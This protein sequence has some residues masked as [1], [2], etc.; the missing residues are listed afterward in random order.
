MEAGGWK[1]LKAVNT[2]ERIKNTRFMSS[3]FS[4]ARVIRSA[5]NSS[6]LSETSL[7]MFLK[8]YLKI[9]CVCYDKNNLFGQPYLD[10]QK[11]PSFSS[12]KIFFQY[13]AFDSTEMY[14]CNS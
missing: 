3:Y 6:L 10:C 1:L 8:H 5:K 4:G 14:S 11:L 9:P 12:R 13:F 2:N 7:Q